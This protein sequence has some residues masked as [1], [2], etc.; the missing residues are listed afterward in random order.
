MLWNGRLSHVH[1]ITTWRI[2]RENYWGEPHAIDCDLT[3]FGSRSANQLLI[4]IT[5]ML[6]SPKYRKMHEKTVLIPCPH[7]LKGHSPCVFPLLD[8]QCRCCEGAREGET[9]WTGMLTLGS[10]C[11]SVELKFKVMNCRGLWG[12]GP[13]MI[14]VF[15][16]KTFQIWW[17]TCVC[18]RQRQKGIG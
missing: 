2:F 9:S 17:D 1:A 7:Y 5:R 16:E 12:D 15:R 3:L 6:L 4:C 8:S 18:Q 11:W 10:S 13:T 14:W